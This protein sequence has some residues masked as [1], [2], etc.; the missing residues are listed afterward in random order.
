MLT[1]TGAG[2]VTVRASQAGNGTYTAATDV[3]QTFQVFQA[4]ATIVVTPYDV[5]YDGTAHTAT[6]TAT[7]LAGLDLSSLLTL[8]GTTHTDA[9]TYATDGWSF[10]GNTNYKAASGTV[11]DKIAQINA[12]IVV[13]PYNVNYD[14]TAHTATGTATGLN[15]LDLSS[16][17]T[18]TGTTHT[19][20]GTYTTDGWSFAGNTNYKA[21]SGTVTD[22]IAKVNAIITV[23]PYSVTY[24]GNPHTATATAK[25]VESV[26]ADLSSLLTLT[27]TTHTNAGDY[28]AD[29]WSFAGN[30]NYNPASGTVHDA[31]AKANAT[32][33]VTGYTGVYDGNPH[34]ATGTA[35]GVKG[36]TLSGLNLGASFTDVPGGT[37]N[38]T[39][40]DAT[41]N[42]NNASG[43]VAITLTK[44]NAIISVTPYSVIYDGNPHTATGTATG[45]KGESL[46]SLLTLSGTTHTN[47][48]DYLADAWS[49]AG[50]TNYNS[51]SG[52]V[53]DV[54]TYGFY[55]LLSP[56]TPNKSYKIK[57]AIPLKWQYTNAADVPIPSG[58]AAPEIRILKVA[59][60]A[61]SDGAITLD[62]AGASGYQYDSTTNTWQFNWKTTGLT[63]GT[64]YVYITSG[65]TN[66]VNG[67]FP[68]QLTN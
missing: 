2:Y 19:D 59:D 44:A 67:P 54:I 53:H 60:Y 43:S 40:T 45:V 28:P 4:E 23:T 47:P 48:G 50:N 58:T 39:F 10:A 38:W 46:T 49:F 16:L 7:G 20:A 24:D 35:T 14:G 9:G 30:T 34:G 5:N 18:L 21:A 1:L 13:T 32:I 22:K 55:G 42:Y 8:S 33:N 29:A 25:G 36:E 56:Y 11:T 15:S 62:D 68:I 52:T 41:G 65:V 63:P 26:P 61:S 6:G 3:D 31:I 66:Q 17:L 57:S 64:Y 12:T 37:A 51:A 27:G